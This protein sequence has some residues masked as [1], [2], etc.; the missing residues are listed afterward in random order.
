MNEQN[1][2]PPQIPPR[3]PPFATPSGLP[4]LGDDQAEH[5]PISNVV[6]AVDAILR[7]PRRVMFQ[8]RQPEAGKL[9]GMMLLVSVVCSLIY[10]VVAG[11]FSG[12]VQLWG[13][14]SKIA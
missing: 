3:I 2:V 12:G 6:A 13:A 4:Q 9:I 8:L 11:T 7:H 14:P 5:L 1:P 10:G